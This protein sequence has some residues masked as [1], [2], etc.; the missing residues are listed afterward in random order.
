MLLANK[1]A[2][3][4]GAAQGIGCTIAER[5]AE[6][7]ARVV[8]ADMNVDTGAATV[9]ALQEAGHDAIF[10]ELN[11]AD[12]RTI[13]ATLTRCLEAFGAVDILVNNAGINS[14]RRVVDL[15]REEWERVLAVNL[16]GPFLCSQI[17]ARHMIDHRRGDC[18][19]FMSSEAGKRGEAGASAY[20]AS[21]FGVLGLME[22]LALEMAPYGIR[23]NAVCPGS[24]DAGMHNW[25]L[26]EIALAEGTSVSELRQSLVDTIPLGRLADPREV[27]N[28]FVFLAS[29]LASFITG[30]S[31]NVDGGVRSG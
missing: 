23:V 15:A 16:T 8:I 3:I 1:V 12:E 25:L 21:K 26:N 24:V 4:T 11:V 29:P 30:E 18:I 28:T 2:V 7:G 20:A 10:S 5:F 22:C 14:V 27:A 17:F 19:L 9:Q 6:E 13:K 31:I